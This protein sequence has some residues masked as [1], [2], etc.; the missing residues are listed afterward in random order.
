MTEN[1]VR[2]AQYL[3]N[4]TSYRIRIFWDGSTFS[5]FCDKCNIVSLKK[6]SNH[7]FKTL[8]SSFLKSLVKRGAFSCNRGPLIGTSLEEIY[9]N[10]SLYHYHVRFFHFQFCIAS[11]YILMACYFQNSTRIWA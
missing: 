9:L 5:A 10:L 11:L 8:N 6:T 3:R 1:Y 4:H 7:P 2:Y